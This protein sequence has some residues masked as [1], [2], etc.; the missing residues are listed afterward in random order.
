MLGLRITFQV[1]HSTNTSPKVLPRKKFWSRFLTSES[2]E[3]ISWKNTPDNH[4][5]DYFSTFFSFFFL[6]GWRLSTVAMTFE[7]A[8]LNTLWGYL[9]LTYK[10]SS[11]NIYSSSKKSDKFIPKTRRRGTENCGG[12]NFL[13]EKINL[14]RFSGGA[15]RSLGDGKLKGSGKF[16]PLYSEKCRNDH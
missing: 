7:F 6:L 3:W 16:C 14:V 8:K 11:R 2:A 12:K 13:L 10:R 9:I 4:T 15:Y 1:Q 5:M